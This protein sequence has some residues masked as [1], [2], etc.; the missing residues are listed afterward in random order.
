MNTEYL[1]IE[2]SRALLS[3]KEAPLKNS[4]NALTPYVYQFPAR[5]D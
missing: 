1:E 5:F 3:N 4:S 2:K